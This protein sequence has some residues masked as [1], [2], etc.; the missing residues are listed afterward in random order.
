MLFAPVEAL[1][2]HF[3][4]VCEHTIKEQVCCSGGAS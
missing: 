2:L 1:S 3:V 4:E